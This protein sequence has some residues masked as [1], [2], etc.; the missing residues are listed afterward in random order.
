MTLNFIPLKEIQRIRKFVSDEFLL[1]RILADVSRFNA[2]YMI[3]NTGSGHVGSSFSAMDI[4]TWL[5]TR[6]MTSP[7]EKNA[8]PS[9]TYFSSKGHDVPGLYSLLLGL[10]KLDFE[11]IYKLRRLGGLPGHPDRHT[12][13]MIAN[14]GPLGMGIS[15][16]RGMAIAN[17]L[18]GKKGRFYVLTGDGEL[19]EGQIW[20]SLRTAANEKLSEITAIVDQNKIQSDFA[21][22]DTNDLGNLENK[23]RAFGW[24][25]VSC[26]GHD[27]PSLKNAFARC[28]KISDRPQAILAN[29]VKGK[30]I[31][32][33][34]KM[35]E[36]GY[37]KFHSGAP[38]PENYASGVQELTAGINGLLAKAGQPFLKLEGRKILPRTG[39]EN[40]QRLVRAYGDELVKI[41]RENKNIVALDADLTL[42]TGLTQFKKEFPDRLVES[43]ISEQDMVSAAGGLA[44][45]GKLPIVHSFACFLTTR[46]NEQIYNNASEGTKIIYAGSLAGLLPAMPGHSHQSV[47]DISVLG[48]I[49][50]L[51]LIQP[52]NEAETRLALR[53]AIQ[54][55]PDSTYLRLT[56]IAC[57][58]LFELPEGYN[59]RPGRGVFIKDGQDAAIIAYGPLMLGEAVKA[60]K[61]LESEG[62]SLAVINLP[63]LNFIDEQW[64]AEATGK[65]KKVFT[66][67][68]H[69]VNLGQGMRI[70]GAI[71]YGIEKLPVCGH[72]G[73]V[74][75]HHGLDFRSLVE[76][77]KLVS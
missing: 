20:E 35:G 75:R 33:M 53:W 15:K 69:Y 55:N 12:P 24:E 1:P 38:S 73:E 6:E 76:K 52:A 62:I 59:L 19:Q 48:S 37:Y 49:P 34:E 63:W 65:Y 60:A 11:L 25:V 58:T 18:S 3:M 68:D 40:P 23:F 16:A 30:G 28:R 67:D 54:E 64:L 61:V 39:V 31:S 5:W 50:G 17:R 51:T 77:I 4:V 7:N 14:T 45:Y 26:D 42:D 74:L 13:Y 21:V 56:S 27:F 8:D 9:D 72:N 36:D 71:H 10:E 2:L 41:A 66:L 70:A 43:G 47:R 22:K 46:A 32:V 57:E 44:L 29:T